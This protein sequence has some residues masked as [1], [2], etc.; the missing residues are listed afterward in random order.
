MYER[1]FNRFRAR[2]VALFENSALQRSLQ[3]ALQLSSPQRKR[4]SLVCCRCSAL[5]QGDEKRRQL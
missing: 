3:F 1:A 4:A 5:A 2:T